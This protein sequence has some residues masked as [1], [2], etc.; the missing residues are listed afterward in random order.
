MASTEAAGSGGAKLALALAP[1]V[2]SNSGLANSLRELG[3]KL[4]AEREPTTRIAIVGRLMGLL[5]KHFPTIHD[6]EI[7]VEALQLSLALETDGSVA[8]G[9]AMAGIS[10]LSRGRRLEL[11]DQP[12]RASSAR[13]SSRSTSSL[14]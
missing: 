12:P 8:G 2:A 4:E 5:R 6:P 13:A 14:W 9:E 11:L 3:K 1:K 10:S 7:A